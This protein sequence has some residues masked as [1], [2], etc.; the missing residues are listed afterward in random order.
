MHQT[1][2]LLRANGFLAELYDE[3]R[4]IARK[5]LQDERRSHTLAATALVHEAYLNLTRTQGMVWQSKQHFFYTAAR[6]MRRILVGYSQNRN[7]EKRGGGLNR[8]S[9]EEI[10]LAL[11]ERKVDLVALD[12]LLDRLAAMDPLLARIVELRFFAGLT[13]EKTAEVLGI[14]APKVK[15]QWK[16]AQAWLL[17]ELRKGERRGT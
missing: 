8:I 7:T 3:L 16:L 9:I 10:E 17:R 14:S 1:A 15:R 5:Y 11:P 13:T 4:R 2:D 12:E 6:A